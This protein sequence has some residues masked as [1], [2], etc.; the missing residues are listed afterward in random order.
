[1]HCKLRFAFLG[2]AVALTAT[3]QHTTLQIDG[4]R[5]LERLRAGNQRYLQGRFDLTRTGAAARASLAAG[6]HP[7]ATVLSCSDSRVPPELIFSQG[8]GDLF[9]VR[10]AGAVPDQTVLGSIEYAAEHLHVPLVVVMGHLSCGAVK[11]AMDSSAPLHL[12]PAEANLERI[13]SP[14]RLSLKRAPADGDPWA[15]AVYASVD[16]NIEDALR[17]SPVLAELAEHGK[18]MVVGAVYDIKSGKVE[19]LNLAHRSTA[20]VRYFR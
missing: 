9:V 20:V 2:M 3:A 5:A 12:E 13:L 8:L 16:Q 11:S 19:F 18:V 14:L 15:N 4:P 10:V 6:Q 17:L 1:M 7:F